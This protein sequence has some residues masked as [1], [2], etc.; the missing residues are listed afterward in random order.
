[1]QVLQGKPGQTSEEI[2]VQV[3]SS[4]RTVRRRLAVLPVTKT[5]DQRGRMLYSPANPEAQSAITLPT[6]EPTKDRSEEPP[7]PASVTGCDNSVTSKKGC[8]VTVT[9]TMYVDIFRENP[10][11]KFTILDLAQHFHVTQDA[12]RQAMSRVIRRGPVSRI[13]SGLFQYD[14]TKE[15]GNLRSVLRS[16][17]WKFENLALVTKGTRYSTL[18]HSEPSTEPEK[19]PECDNQNTPIP[20]PGPDCIPHPDWPGMDLP[21]GQKIR[22][23][24]YPKTGTEWI[25]ISA[26][27][28]P[29][30][31]PDYLLFI[32]GSILKDHGFD[33]A[34][35][36]L[37]SVEYLIDSEKLR[38]EGNHTYQAFEK[39]VFKGYN[40]GYHGR[41]EKADRRITPADE[42]I[43]NC[44]ILATGTLNAQAIRE[45]RSLKRE[46]EEIG[47]I[48][49]TAYSIAD[50]ERDI[51]IEAKRS[52][53]KQK[54]PATFT[55]GAAI[56]QEQAPAA[57]P[58]AK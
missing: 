57:A 34:K 30:I 33:P 2:A 40:H 35:W 54:P 56:K 22:K 16:G 41:F 39:E 46:V 45:V 52:T 42:F 36:D 17:N 8:R 31:S 18:S 53:K 11:R 48:A 6:I 50:K 21:T 12:V 7:K 15:D 29:P 37:V 19:N 58:G 55:T 4:E 28:A 5:E 10:N 20:A 38:Y 47:K 9:L 3:G 49:R 14:P 26:K 51:R 23:W 32:I 13:A 25:T 43:E 44:R 1:M 24:L 27:G